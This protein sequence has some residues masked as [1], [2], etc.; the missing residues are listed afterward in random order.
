MS[1]RILS[2]LLAM[3]MLLSMV[4]FQALAEDVTETEATVV[5]QTEAP[6]VPETTVAPV[7]P[8]TTEAPAVPETTEAPAVEPTEAPT[9]EPTEAPAS[10]EPAKETEPAVVAQSVTVSQED[11]LNALAVGGQLQ[12]TA[13][14][15]PEDTQD[16]TVVWTSSD[17]AV[18]T[19]DETGLVTG[20]GTG[21]VTVTAACGE[22][23][24]TYELIVSAPV[25]TLEVKSET[26]QYTVIGSVVTNPDANADESERTVRAGESLTL[27]AEDPEDKD[28]VFL[29]RFVDPD[30]A[31]YARLTPGGILTPYPKAVLE[32][33][34]IFVQ[35]YNRDNEYETSADIKLILIPRVSRVN[36]DVNGED[37][38]NKEIL[39]NI[40]KTDDV[41]INATVGPKDAT[42]GVSW[43]INGSESLYIKP[44]TDNAFSLCLDHRDKIGTI[45]VTA[46]ALDGS[47]VKARTTIRFVKLA[48]RIEI[49]H[50]PEE[51]DSGT[52]FM[53]GG[54]RWTLTTNLAT[55][56][57]LSD[58]GV[59]WQVIDDDAEPDEDGNYPDSEYATIGRDNGLLATSADIT[60]KHLI[61]VLAWVAADLNVEPAEATIL[62]YPGAREVRAWAVD[63]DDDM[64]VPLAQRTVELKAEILPADEAMQNVTWTI[65]NPKLAYF[66]DIDENGK[67]VE[68]TKVT[69]T[70]N[71]TLYLKAAGNVRI[72]AAAKDGSGKKAFVNL[73]ITAPVEELTI[74]PIVPKDVDPEDDLFL[75]AGSSL[76][77]KAETWTQYDPD[78]KAECLLA[79]NQKVTWSIY[80]LNA[81]GEPVKTSA[82]SIS[83]AGRV[84]AGTVER[85]TKVIAKAVSVE[86]TEDNEISDTREITITPRLARTLAVFADGGKFSERRD[87]KLGANELLDANTTYNIIGKYYDREQDQYFTVTDDC[88]FESSNK[89]VASIDEFGNL[90]TGKSGTADIYVKWVD[91]SDGAR[92]QTVKITVKV[93]ALVN[94]VTITQPKSIYVRSGSSLSLK[95]TAW[96]QQFSGVKAS[97]QKFTWSVVD[98]EEG[99]EPKKY[100]EFATMSGSTLKPKAVTE[101]KSVRVYAES[102]E[103]G[104]KAYIDIYILPKSAC[105]L[106]LSFEDMEGELQTGTVIVP[107]NLTNA[108]DLKLALYQSVV[109][110]NVLTILENDDDLSLSDGRITWKT[111]NK[112]VIA[113]EGGVPVFKGTGKVTLTAK[114]SD[115]VNK[116]SATAKITL[117]LVDAVTSIK[118]TRKVAGQ[119]L[120]QGRSISLVALVEADNEGIPVM[121]TNRSVIW[122][123]ADD[124]ES[125]DNATINPRS[126]V[127]TA[128]KNAKIGATV[129]AIATPADGFSDLAVGKIELTILPLAEKV[130]I[131]G[132]ENGETYTVHL[133]DKTLPLSATVEGPADA[134]EDPS[135]D[136]KW[137]SNNSS[138]ASVDQNGLVT[139][140]RGNRKVKITAAATDGSGK[141]TSIILDIKD[142]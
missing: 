92:M 125:T 62:L 118:V 84:A 52:P 39:V 128:K 5:E 102:A 83:A 121:P 124:E 12:L 58:R 73:K 28:K 30:D 21:T 43:T 109:S 37:A 54:T 80:E 23:T 10:T 40:D 42:P 127:V 25:D 8:E 103:N 22:V 38:T 105:Q 113:I 85:N 75:A 97:N 104:Q 2:L 48:T 115:K 34:S 61:K 4:P 46:T 74:T 95:A 93:Q 82:A 107:R 110:G 27:T 56:R 130:V 142:D 122:S 13:L 114:Y 63:V 133:S 60:Q 106:T 89:K 81:D 35:A 15:L 6:A 94:S 33:R 11:E 19:V 139:F 20:I 120:I 108:D 41:V 36:L 51:D 18:A 96:N 99:G 66:E 24:G 53:I 31:G 136:V 79:E 88:M 140:K 55:D 131:D 7:V 70:M 50:L 72:T 117:N 64:K 134:T 68:L 87:E 49:G 90:T 67:K 57:N 91:D 71:P 112:K 137:S 101:M 16:K 126:G 111:S 65:S 132:R 45:T 14:V 98:L 86:S 26:A 123:L 17:E 77:L 138:Y 129:T 9:V 76:N 135:Q 78:D 59:I 1:K 29:W 3:V 32:Q 119:E 47:G 141:K 116:Q 44:D 100:S 69:D